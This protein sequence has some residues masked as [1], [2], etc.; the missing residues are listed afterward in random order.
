VYEAV[1]ASSSSVAACIWRVKVA[2]T[3]CVC[4]LKPLVY[5]A[6]AASSSSVAARTWRRVGTTFCAPN[7][8]M[9]MEMQSVEALLRPY[10]GYEGFIKAQERMPTEMQFVKALL[11]HY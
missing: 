10:R 11:R 4:G 2:T 8:R 9:P 3:F 7:E 6:V 5:E 1:A